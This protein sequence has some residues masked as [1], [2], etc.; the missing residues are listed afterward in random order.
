M[1]TLSG[2]KREGYVFIR[3]FLLK[4]KGIIPL[5]FNIFTLLK[6]KLGEELDGRAVSALG[7]RS[8]KLSTGLN[9]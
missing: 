3:K 6:K 4:Q 1:S 8:R 9:R 7:V 5:C 2:I